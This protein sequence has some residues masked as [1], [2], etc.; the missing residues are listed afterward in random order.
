LHQRQDSAAGI[1][2]F[3]F[4]RRIPAIIQKCQ[5]S[6]GKFVAGLCTFS[7]VKGGEIFYN[8]PKKT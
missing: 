7:L 8:V 5:I 2:A 4:S 6:Q 3:E 1:L